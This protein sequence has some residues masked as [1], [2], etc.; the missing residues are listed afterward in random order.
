[1]DDLPV[2]WATANLESCVD[3]LDSQRIPVNSDERERRKGTTPYYGATGQV[4]W[5]DDFLFDEEL[6]LIGEDGAPFFDKSKLIS[7]VI[8]GK[9]WVNNHAHVL[10]AIHGLTTN[11]FLKHYLNQFDFT[12]YVNGT[13][14]L[15]LTQ[16]SLKAIP[17]KIPPSHEQR[18]IVAKLE[19]LLAKVD[20]CKERLEKIPAILKRFR[21]SVLAAAFSGSLTSAFRK[22]IASC[23]QTE[24]PNYENENQQIPCPWRHT[25][26]GD[27]ISEGPKNGLYKPQSDYG[28]GVRIVRI[29]NFYD[30]KITAWGELKRLRVSEKEL[31]DYGLQNDDLVINRVNSMQFLG[32]SGLVR[33]LDAPCV[34]ESNMMRI[35]VKK[36]LVLP[37][38]L[39]AYLNSST[40]LNELRKNAKHA[41]NQSSINQ[42]DVQNA[43][44]VLPPLEEQAIIIQKL[45]ELFQLSEKIILRY[46]SA[47]T[48]VAKLTQSILAKAFRGELA[49]QDPDDEPASE[50][51][52]RI[53]AEREK[54]TAEGRKSGRIRTISKAKRGGRKSLRLSRS[55]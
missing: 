24:A 30:G 28:S 55:V 3:I 39:I 20:A 51:L 16:G 50:L 45:N 4:G 46:Q 26:L 35:R 40:G 38:Y 6:L 25:K 2:R 44:V 7:Y 22:S 54:K 17:V 5:I 9:S 41:V 23:S 32:K 37:E 27:L 19:K 11:V 33:G 12:G 15:K 18:R 36:E 49:P 47:N 10:R 31:E 8:K 34:F 48:Q 42:H 53:H 13:T 43:A 21:Q 52:K 29:D 1:M 14:R